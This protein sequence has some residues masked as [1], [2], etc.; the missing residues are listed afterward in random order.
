MY[1]ACADGSV[2]RLRVGASVSGIGR[3]ADRPNARAIG[4][5]MSAHDEGGDVIDG[6]THDDCMAIVAAGGTGAEA[7]TA[8]VGCS[9]FAS[10]H[11][12]RCSLIRYLAIDAS[13]TGHWTNR[14]VEICTFYVLRRP[15]RRRRAAIS[16]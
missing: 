12:S 10:A 15:A 14:D 6:G 1:A 13:H 5:D 8:V 11:R 4:V 16:Y 9:T 2:G 3:V 7:I